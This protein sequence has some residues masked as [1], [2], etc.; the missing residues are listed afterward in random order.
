MEVSRILWDDV[1]MYEYIY[2]CHY[3]SVCLNV[4]SNLVD[5]LG[6]SMVL[7]LKVYRR[8]L[9]R[10][11]LSTSWVSGGLTPCQQ[12]R[13]S[14]WRER[15][16]IRESWCHKSGPYPCCPLGPSARE[17]RSASPVE[18]GLVSPLLIGLKSPETGPR[19]RAM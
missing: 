4:C 1:C 11:R 17:L 3:V 9:P 6:L 18:Q 12:L 10:E 2:I 16:I 8:L 15:C 19:S 5:V 13:P 14:S 7:R